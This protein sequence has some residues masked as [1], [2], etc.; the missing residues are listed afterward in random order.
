M[1]SVIDQIGCAVD[2]PGQVNSIVSLVPSQTELLFD[3]GLGDKVVGVTKFCVRPANAQKQ[4]SLVGG[5]KSINI[6]EI[7]KLKPDLVIG[8]KEEN[9]RQHVERLQQEFPTWV[10]DIASFDDALDMIQQL[11]EILDRVDEGEKLITRIVSGFQSL[12]M[13]PPLKTL[14]FIWKKPYMVAGNNT[15]INTMLGKIGLIN[16]VSA[17]RYPELSSEKIIQ[18]NPELILLSSEPFP[19]KEKDKVEIKELVPSAE[20]KMV[21]GAMFSWYGSGLAKAPSYFNSL[22]F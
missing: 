18:L 6:K 10:S 5:T 15:F 21:D 4:A 2:L 8:N 17:N 13:A 7:Q 22:F 3:L 14:Y 1:G 19:F 11:S 16:L 20:I 12:A 9:T